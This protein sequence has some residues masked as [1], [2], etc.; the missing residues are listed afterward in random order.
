MRLRLQKF[1]SHSGY[2]SRR[3]SEKLIKD[4][5]VYVNGKKAVIGDLVDPEKD[6]IIVKNKKVSLPQKYIYIAFNKPIGF[7]SSCSNAQGPSIFDLIKIKEKVYPVG[8]LDKDSEGLMILT[9]DGDLA[10]FL[11]HPRFGCEKEYE[12]IIDDELNSLEINNFSSGI[13][14]DSVKTK[15]CYIRKIGNK[16]YSVILKEGKKRQIR[17]MFEFFGKRVLKLKRVRIKSVSLNGLK[18]GSWRYLTRKE[19][20]GLRKFF[21]GE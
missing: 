11:T 10:N 6:E 2:A 3:N 14:L 17:R 9:N 1:L 21:R 20:D 16:K 13:Y 19:I 12:V 4:G 8:R 7:I 15:P 18:Q 5:F